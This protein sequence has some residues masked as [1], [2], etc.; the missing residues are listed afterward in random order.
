MA[1]RSRELRQ[2]LPALIAGL[3]VTI[4]F[5]AVL[6]IVLTAAGPEGWGSPIGGP[7]AGSPSSTGSR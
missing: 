6:S 4:V 2:S 3:T 1:T 7:A 5:F